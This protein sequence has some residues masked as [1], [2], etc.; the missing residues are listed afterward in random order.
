MTIH[1]VKG[2]V[3]GA[4]VEGGL[5]LRA[6]SL[7]KVLVEFRI[8]DGGYGSGVPQ[9]VGAVGGERRA[10]GANG[11]SSEL[12]AALGEHRKGALRRGG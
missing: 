7:D 8:A 1:V 5:P 10:E 11:G 4:V 12:R 9:C 2:G 3:C 6:R